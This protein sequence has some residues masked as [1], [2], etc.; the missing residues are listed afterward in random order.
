MRMGSIKEI[1]EVTF[2]DESLLG[3]VK[4]GWKTVQLKAACGHV[5]L[6][7][8]LMLYTAG[9]GFVSIYFNYYFIKIVKI[10]LPNKIE[11]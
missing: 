7:L 8:A 4:R 6:L 11:H 5:G 10:F 2:E 3:T 1:R 9:G